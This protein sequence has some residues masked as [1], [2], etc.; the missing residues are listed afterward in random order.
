[1]VRGTQYMPVLGKIQRLL[2]VQNP[3]SSLELESRKLKMHAENNRP[4]VLSVFMFAVLRSAL[5]SPT[6]WT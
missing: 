5:D 6:A 4:T 3:N 1:M 2:S